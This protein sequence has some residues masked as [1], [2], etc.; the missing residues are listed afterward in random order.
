M[1]PPPY[2]HENISS[3]I[4]VGG[5]CGERVIVVVECIFEVKKWHA[6]TADGLSFAGFFFF[7]RRAG[8]RGG[9]QN[10]NHS[11]FLFTKLLLCRDKARIPLLLFR[12]RHA[13]PQLIV[14]SYLNA[15]GR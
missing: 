14:S 9:R 3:I 10:L 13:P 15:A 12:Q 5:R 2:T 11:G 4:G 8:A 1:G 6:Q 7:S